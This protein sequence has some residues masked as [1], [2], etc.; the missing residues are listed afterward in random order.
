MDGWFQIGKGAGT[1]AH[2]SKCVSHAGVCHLSGCTMYVI[3]PEPSHSGLS[4]SSCPKINVPFPF[5]QWCHCL[6]SGLRRS[7]RLRSLLPASWAQGQAASPIPFIDWCLWASLWDAPTAPAAE[8]K[9]LPCPHYSPLQVK[10]GL[11]SEQKGISRD[12]VTWNTFYKGSSPSAFI[13][14]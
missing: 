9:I 14:A 6:E 8:L 12:M 13:F 5:L 10:A 3:S 2:H 4:F 7:C 11:W 1:P